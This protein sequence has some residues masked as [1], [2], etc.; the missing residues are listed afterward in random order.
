MTKH[1][2]GILL[3]NPRALRQRTDLICFESE[4]TVKIGL[5]IIIIIISE[6]SVSDTFVFI[7]VNGGILNRRNDGGDVE[8]QGR[9]QGQQVGN[10]QREVCPVH[11]G[12]S[13]STR[14]TLP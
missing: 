14:K 3:A 6:L 11:T 5:S 12:T 13:R 1:E 9:Q 7:V 10:G 4:K 8:L 2:S